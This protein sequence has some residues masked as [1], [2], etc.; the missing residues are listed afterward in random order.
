M[1]IE[2]YQLENAGLYF[3]GHYMMPSIRFD[4]YNCRFEIKLED[5]K[6]LAELFS[7]FGVDSEN[8]EWV[9]KLIGKYCRIHFDDDFNLV[10][11]QHITN[12]KIV[13]LKD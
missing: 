13:F 5:R 11:V 9:H 10:A 7:I 1:S 4:F 2:N 3:I 12:N 6:R 8:G